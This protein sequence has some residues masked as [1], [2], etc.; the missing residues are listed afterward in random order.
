MEMLNDCY[1]DLAH[2][3]RHMGDNFYVI[4]IDITET[5]IS[6]MMEKN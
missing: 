3:V 4:T 5:K 1:Y 2:L 6:S